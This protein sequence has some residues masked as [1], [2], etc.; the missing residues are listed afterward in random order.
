[1]KKIFFHT[2][3][4]LLAAVC[5]I[6]TGC[7]DFEPTG[8]AAVP[9][10]NPASDLKAEI[11]GYV[12]N[13]SWNLPATGDIEGVQVITNGRASNPVTLEGR[14]T[15]YAVKGQPMGENY[16]YTVKVN[17]AGG[18]VSEGVSVE[19]NIP[20][21]ALPNVTDLKAAVNGRTVTL[22]WNLPAGDGITGVKVI[23]DGDVDAATLIEGRPTSCVLKG[24][25]M[26]KE[27]TYTVAVVFDEFYTSA[28]TSVKAIIPYITPKMGY[29]MLAPSISELPDDDE[30]AAATWFVEQ[31]NAELLM[32]SQLVDIDADI[33]SV[34]WIE[35]DR[36][37][38]PIGWEN[39]PS[40]VTNDATIEALRAYTANGGSLYL[41]NMA[42]QL[43]VPLGIVPSDMGPNIFA[44]GDGGEGTDVW[45]INPFLG[46]DF[47][48]GSDQGFY[49][50]TAHAIYKGLTLEDP[51]GYGYLTLPLI[52][53]GQR[54]D[55][56]CMWDCNAYGRGNQAD[57]IKNFEVTTN[58]LV[59]A[60][61][62]HVRDHCVAGLVEFYANA[63][64]GRCIANGFAAYEWNQNSGANPY[65]H[66]VEQLTKNILEYL[67]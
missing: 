22:N 23:R 5:L 42:T 13:L 25:P 1:M 26:D 53:P 14:A 27:M 67:K 57:V 37:G 63:Q 46:W 20:E 39:L 19:A 18:Y 38:L 4:I 65:Q 35:I 15:S 21:V 7:S 41:S 66:N 31:E 50:R 28:G 62:G 54:E 43:T 61:W 56:N 58:S 48:N 10:L 45:V 2:L 44:S 47:R 59:L 49:D 3:S 51:N 40:E 11:S 33:Y 52:G 29:L 55:H 30:R 34:I 64:H 8:Y 17:Y 60:T 24:Q 6:S 36:V 16:M 9:D 32:P 12:V